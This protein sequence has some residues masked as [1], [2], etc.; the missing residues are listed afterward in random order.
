[1]NMT[2]KILIP[3]T[4][5]AS[6]HASDLKPQCAIPIKPTSFSDNRAIR[7]YNDDANRYQACMN[8]FIRKHRAI[9][10]KEIRAVNDAVAE[11]N[12]FA[13]GKPAGSK[14]NDS[15]SAHTGSTDGHHTVDKSDPTMFY[16][17]L[18]F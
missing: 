10:D 11:W 4:I 16:K 7:N 14:K 5:L 17:N 2:T 1:M 15:I 3:L 18:K 6:L 8:D 13:T 9:A 12:S